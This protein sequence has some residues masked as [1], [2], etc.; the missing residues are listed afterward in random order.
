MVTVTVTVTEVQRRWL[1]S[2]PGGASATVRKLVAEKMG[3]EGK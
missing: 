1:L 3:Q 2:Q